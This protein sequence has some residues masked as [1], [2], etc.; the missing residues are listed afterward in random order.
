MPPPLHPSL[1]SRPVTSS[2]SSQQPTYNAPLHAQRPPP[3]SYTGPAAAVGR[4]RE[5]TP[6]SL[7][8]RPSFLPQ[9]PGSPRPGAGPPG[10]GGTPGSLAGPAGGAAAGGAGAGTAEDPWQTIPPRLKAEDVRP[11]VGLVELGDGWSVRW[12]AWKAPAL[13]VSSSSSSSASS[14]S[15]NPSSSTS[16]PSSLLDYDPFAPPPG[17]VSP[18][19]RSA[20]RPAN[21]AASTSAAP[22]PDPASTAGTPSAQPPPA[23]KPKRANSGSRPEAGAAGKGT[24]GGSTAKVGNAFDELVAEDLKSGTDN[25]ESA[26][27]KKKGR[28]P[29]ALREAQAA[30][31]AAAAALQQSQQSQGAPSPLTGTPSSLSAS[32]SNPLDLLAPPPVGTPALSSPSAFLQTPILP[33]EDPPLPSTTPAPPPAP[34]PSG[35]SPAQRARD[36]LRPLSSS[37]SASSFVDPVLSAC[38]QIDLL[39]S[40]FTSSSAAAG[41]SRSI[42][43]GASSS[44]AGSSSEEEEGE[45]GETKERREPAGE[46]ERERDRLLLFS[47]VRVAPVKMGVAG[48]AGRGGKKGKGKERAVEEPDVEGGGKKRKGGEADEGGE[49]AKEGA[50]QDESEKKDEEREAEGRTLWVFSVVRGGEEESEKV[51]KVKSAL[52]AMGFEGLEP[53]ASGTFTHQTLFPALYPSSEASTSTYTSP[54]CLPARSYPSCLSLSSQLLTVTLMHDSLPSKTHLQAAY[55]A[56][57]EGAKDVVLDEMCFSPSHPSSSL[58]APRPVRLKDS[59]LYL[60]PPLPPAFASLPNLPPSFPPSSRLAVKTTLLPPSLNRTALL[61]QPHLSEV[62]LSPLPPP[63]LHDRRVRRGAPVILLPEG[64]KGTYLR[65]VRV[66]DEQEQRLTE[67]W[68]NHLSS[69]HNAGEDGW[70]LCAIDLPS[71]PISSP[72]T[73]ERRRRDRLE[74]VFP[75]SLVLLDGSRRASPSPR[76]SSSS[77]ASKSRSRS[78]GRRGEKVNGLFFASSS[79]DEADAGGKIASEQ[80]DAESRS[81]PSSPEQQHHPLSLSPLRLGHRAP[82]DAAYRRRLASQ[83]LAGVGRSGSSGRGRRVLQGQVEGMQQHEEGE[84]EEVGGEGGGGYKGPVRRRTGEV[85]RWMGEE[86]KRRK[87]EERERVERV[88][89]EER[90]EREKDTVMEEDGAEEEDGK[91]EEIL[92]PPP[93]HPSAPT[94][95]AAAPSP[96]HPYPPPPPSHASAPINMRTPMSLG[97]ASTE[98]PSPAELFSLTGSHAL[99]QPLPPPLSSAA[100]QPPSQLDVDFSEL[101]VYPSPAEPPAAAGA[102]AVVVPASTGMSTLDAAFSSFNWGDGTFGAGTSAPPASVPPV[103]GAGSAAGANGVGGEFDDGMMLGLTDDDFSFFDEPI[104]PAASV[105]AVSAIPLSSSIDMGPVGGSSLP[106]S[107][108]FDLPLS[109]ADPHHHH[110]ALLDPF[111]FV[112]YGDHPTTTSNALGLS[113]ASQTSVVMA[114]AEALLVPRSS[115]PEAALYA[116]SAP[117]HLHEPTSPLLSATTASTSA[118]IASTA[119]IP[120][121]PPSPL[122]SLSPSFTFSPHRTSPSSSV[123]DPI[124]FALSHTQL[125]AKYDPRRGKFGLP[126]PESAA[127]EEGSDLG[128][129]GMLELLPSAIGRRERQKD[130]KKTK[131]SWFELV[132]DP[133]I[134]VAERLKLARQQQKEQQRSKGLKSSTVARSRG[135]IRPRPADLNGKSLLFPSPFGMAEGDIP[136]GQTTADEAESAEEESSSDGGNGGGGD[137]GMDVD[138]EEGA[139]K[140]GVRRRADE[141]DDVRVRGTLGAE[142]LLLGSAFEG[143]LERALSGSKE[144]GEAV[145][146][147]II[148]SA[149]EIMLAVVSDAVLFNHEF[150]EATLRHLPTKAN[151]SLVSSRAIS[152]AATSLSCTCTTLSPSP[153]F[154][155]DTALPSLD[156]QE[157]PAFLLRTQQCVVQTTTSAMPFWRLMGFEPLPGGKDLTAF[158]IYE[159]DGSDMHEAVKMWL[160]SMG[161]VYQGLRLGE[162]TPGTI[163]ATSSFSGVQDGLVPLPVGLLTEAH[164]RDELKLLYLTLIEHAKTAQNTVVYIITPFSDSPLSPS[165]PLASILHQIGKSRTA[166]TNMHPV[167]LPLSSVVNTLPSLDGRGELDRLVRLCFS[168]YDSLQLPISRLRIPTPDTFPAARPLPIGAL[169]PAVRL[170]QAPAITLSPSPSKPPQIQFS[171]NWPAASLEVEARHRFLHVCYG[172]ELVTPGN[173]SGEWLSVAMVDEK[174]ESWKNIPRYLKIPAGVVADVHRVRVVWS[175]AKTLIDAADVEWRVVLCKLGEPTALETRAWDSLLKEHLAV[176][177]RPLH[178]TFAS[179]DLDPAVSLSPATPVYRRESAT[180]TIFEDGELSLT[181]VTSTSTSGKVILFDTQ[182]ATFAFTPAEP[183]SLITLPVI[184]PAST[185]IF[186]IPRISSLAHSAVEPFELAATTSSAPISAYAVHFLLSHSSRTSSYTGTLSE[187][188]ADVRQSF[189]ELAALGQARWEMSGR[190][191]WHIEAARASLSLATQI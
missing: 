2:S 10:G 49:S 120:F 76:R 123:F 179:L 144:G 89:R 29:K 187:L 127:G 142:L 12:R 43:A 13:L 94:P 65:E 41:P 75:R 157:S 4:S 97:T 95:A 32:G 137:D 47:W 28:I 176:S 63:S 80:D 88:E 132:C 66:S 74:A 118:A 23:K 156:E 173:S 169:G 26:A 1:P 17:A 122:I 171:L 146:A 111:A 5:S 46:Q 131:A 110:H 71:S 177:R 100:P 7:P 125:D 60:P 104:V 34:I 108:A 167:P 163:V 107:M 175:F 3:S 124:P 61:L 159:D 59:V 189:A 45:E 79:E 16:L 161:G 102:S 112:P 73:T 188:V 15:S 30:Q 38:R 164:G 83:A 42:T 134:P 143:A 191:P 72:P 160:N 135:W 36:F 133:R 151:A 57:R 90:A 183:V 21:A 105:A 67:D 129:G 33:S 153:L 53:L 182:P 190:F 113:Q 166:V 18:F 139:A 64:T 9:T 178:A 148:D 85:W 55:E 106:M 109:G 54:L 145:Q 40:S 138:Y 93:P 37:S 98:A 185:F 155:D 70:V 101:G 170:C 158:A 58:E 91:K 154:A 152:L 130:N 115:P 77:S 50:G 19:S 87:E 141:E 181:P 22:T 31:A 136:T 147:R 14:S 121:H 69:R 51:S 96:R 81:P 126:T 114:A 165:C 82:Y 6:L 84:E 20:A 140:D 25:A 103:T 68:K 92:P 119:V 11:S 27:P 8:N 180:S 99:H 168:I 35:P 128:G 149:I 52:D 116:P 56:F 184:A 186:H 48:A 174:G 44:P 78:Q 150:R 172:S 162:H 62:T 39:A 117:R 24:G 86:V